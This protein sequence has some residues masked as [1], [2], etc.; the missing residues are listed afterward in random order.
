MSEE[1]TRIV[2]RAD[3]K[4]GS[5]TITFQCDNGH[6]INVPAKLAGK[7][8]TCS[9]C[10]IAV[11]I[12][13]AGQP[14]PAPAPQPAFDAA[15][16]APPEP[17]AAEAFAE[18]PAATPAPDAPAANQFA[19]LFEGP[20]A[21]APAV[22]DVAIEINDAGGESVTG[23]GS[24][25]GDVVAGYAPE[26]F[27]GPDETTIVENPTA[28]LVARLWLERGHGGVVELH[29]TGGGVILPEWYEARWSRGT[30]GLFASQA[31]DGTVTLTAV[32]W[33]SIQKVVVRQVEGLPD[34]MFE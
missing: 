4:A 8:G 13:L 33:E 20:S 25:V 15:A 16:V 11:V 27:A 5:G 9:K 17:V 6:R 32:S 21:A 12:P 2:P 26:Q 18:P 31:A 7:R 28:Q 30:H 23:G 29:L 1:K 3:A 24:G 34:G 14:K 19:N 10:G 22:E